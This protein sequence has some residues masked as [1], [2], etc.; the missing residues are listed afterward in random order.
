MQLELNE[1]EKMASDFID[2]IDKRMGE[3]VD[4]FVLDDVSD[5][6]R[7]RTFT[8]RLLAY[9]YFHVYI[10][11]DRGSILCALKDSDSYILLPNSQENYS[12]MDIDKFVEE[13]RREIELRI[14]DKYLKAH[15]YM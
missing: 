5:D 11:F 1:T 15:G 9:N 4:N 12:K 14:P 7:Y 3:Q 10:R 2:A 8:I 6:P 13:L